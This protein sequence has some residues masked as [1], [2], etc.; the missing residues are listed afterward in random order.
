MKDLQARLDEA[1]TFAGKDGKR[2]IQKLELKVRQLETELEVEQRKFQESDRAGKKHE[3]RVRELTVQMEDDRKLH[4]Q[5]KDS[6]EKLQQKIKLYKRQVEEA[7]SFICCLLI[8]NLLRF[9]K[10]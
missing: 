4:D 7:V 5:Y 3:K 6:I 2:L 1:E 10:I 8:K 9:L